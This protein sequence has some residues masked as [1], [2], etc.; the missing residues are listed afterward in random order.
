MTDR[1]LAGRIGRPHGLDGSFHVIDAAPELL[2][3]GAAVSVGGQEAEIVGRKG[4]DAAPILRLSIAADRNEAVGLRGRAI[5]VPKTAA[6]ALEQDEY[7]ADDLVGCRVVVAD[8]RVLGSVVRMIAYPSCDVLELDCEGLLV[9]LVKDAILRVDLPA[10]RIEVDA[11]F[12]GLS[13]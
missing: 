6:P 11:D 7:W 12:L 1:L 13:R 5:E 8:E 2:P 10:R 9:P 3:L 4:T